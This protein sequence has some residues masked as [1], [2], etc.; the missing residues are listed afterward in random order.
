[1]TLTG[2]SFIE[3]CEVNRAAGIVITYCALPWEENCPW[4]MDATSERAAVLDAVRGIQQTQAQLLSAVESL[5]DRLGGS[6][7]ATAP[8]SSTASPSLLGKPFIPLSGS[9]DKTGQDS[10][11]ATGSSSPPS[12]SLE[13]NPHP[14][15]SPI[16]GGQRAGFTSRI[17]LTYVFLAHSCLFKWHL[18]TR[19]QDISEADRNTSPADGLGQCRSTA[20]RAC[21][22]VQS[23]NDNKTSQWLV[24]NKFIYIN[25]C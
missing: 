10:S 3:V 25:A 1:M 20:S 18:L 14:A 15:S 19:D 4:A 16:A 13:S 17:V 12:T 11:R 8:G 6:S 9:H 24:P 2:A 21:C 7:P 23:T 5:N 22:C